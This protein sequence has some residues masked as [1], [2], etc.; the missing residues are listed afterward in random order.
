MSN[1]GVPSD[2]AVGVSGEMGWSS[3]ESTVVGPRGAI[4]WR[5][6]FLSISRKV[7]GRWLYVRDTWNSDTPPP[8]AH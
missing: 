8:A 3:G 5:G 2:R 6:K 7:D 4:A 1:P